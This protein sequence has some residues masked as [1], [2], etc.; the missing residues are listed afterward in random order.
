MRYVVTDTISVSAELAKVVKF[1]IVDFGFIRF[2]TYIE[3][4]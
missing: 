3:I 2:V 1:G 4:V